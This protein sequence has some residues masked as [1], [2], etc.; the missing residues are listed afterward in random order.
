MQFITDITVTYLSL[1][2]VSPATEQTWL[3]CT[4]NTDLLVHDFPSLNLTTLYRRKAFTRT[5]DLFPPSF[6][7]L[8]YVYETT[9][10]YLPF[11]TVDLQPTILHVICSLLGH[12]GGQ[13]S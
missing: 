7:P 2:H 11:L 5:D 3:A 6:T 10:L 4:T 9:V 1:F 13:L 8:T 12:F